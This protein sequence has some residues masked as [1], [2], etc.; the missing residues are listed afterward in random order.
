MR[1]V[2]DN[3]KSEHFKLLAEMAKTLQF[4]VVEIELTEDEEDEELLAAM[5]AVKHEKPVS[6][7][8]AEDFENWLRS[9]N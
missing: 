2:I 9:V 4:K 7:Q 3:F 8:E 1:M 5:E 6:K